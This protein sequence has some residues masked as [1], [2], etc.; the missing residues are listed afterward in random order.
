[1][2][3]CDMGVLISKS[4]KRTILILLTP[5]SLKKWFFLLL[6]AWLAGALGSG[7]NFNFPDSFNGEQEAEGSLVDEAVSLEDENLGIDKGIENLP[8]FGSVQDNQKPLPLTNDIESWDHVQEDVLSPDSASF[9]FFKKYMWGIGIVGILL[10]VPFVLF[11]IWLSAR[12]KFV[13]FDAIVNNDASVIDPFKKYKSEGHS[14]FRFYVLVTVSSG[15][16]LLLLVSWGYFLGKASGIF[17]ADFAWSFFAFMKLFGLQIFILIFSIMAVAFINFIVDHFIVTIMA[18]RNISFV[19]AVKEFWEMFKVNQK[20]VGL[21]IVI[22]IGLAI[23]AGV[24]A[25]IVVAVGGLIAG[26]VGFFIFGLLYLVIAVF[27]K[28]N[29]IFTIL[30]V[31]MGVPFVVAVLIVLIAMGLPFAVF[32]RN[33]SLYFISSLDCGY[34]ALGLDETHARDE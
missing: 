9:P 13:W 8:D 25:L 28:L 34:P 19:P 12:F 33:F 22:N 16:L 29:V 4:F 10:V 15:L 27:L 2:S 23:G 7:G 21:F 32:F 5:F 31:L 3:K 24:M 20:D 17:D 1:M 26:L 6:I 18:M 14:L 30:A 11:S